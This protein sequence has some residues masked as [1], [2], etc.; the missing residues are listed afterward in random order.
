MKDRAESMDPHGAEPVDDD[1]LPRSVEP[2]EAARTGSD[3]W[4]LTC[5]LMPCHQES[6][7]TQT[8][9]NGAQDQSEPLPGSFQDLLD[10]LPIGIVVFS[11]VGAIE[12]C[13]RAAA[14]LL[15]IQR[16]PSA[17]SCACGRFTASKGS[18]VR[19]HV[20]SILKDDA[21]GS[22]EVRMKAP[23]GSMRTILLS[24][25]PIRD[26]AGA[27]AACGSAVIDVTP[28]EL[29]RAE[30]HRKQA[31]LEQVVERQAARIRELQRR[32]E[33]LERLA[34]AGRLAAGAAHEINNPLAGIA[35]AFALV[36]R[37]VPTD[38]PHR[39]MVGLIEREL[40]RITEIVRH[41]HRAYRPKGKDLSCVNVADVF[42]EIQVLLERRIEAKALRVRQDPASSDAEV[43]VAE[44]DLRQIL[45]NLLTNAIDAS[46]R[47]GELL[48]TAVRSASALNIAVSD[49]G[50][51]IA[52]DVLPRIFEPFFTTK[53]DQDAAGMGL[54][55]A[56]SK[57]LAIAMG[58]HIRA[59]TEL[60]RGSTFTL[61]LPLRPAD[62]HG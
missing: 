24:S 41:V 14:S 56:I 8:G 29:D 59:D 51:G 36:K 4:G 10:S 49:Q 9:R 53:T 7:F 26:A 44:S 1:P 19:S 47:G 42:R 12:A 15:G 34:T 31:Y 58:G 33:E 48:M 23:D 45:Y 46:P 21:P 5:R 54:G 37:A 43:L 11:Q 52:P 20:M 30:L 3:G 61:T 62:G 25:A 55:L 18:D 50:E 57:S 39:G 35:N 28:R 17:G 40:Q 22:C 60:G 6:R 27:P 16:N 32:Q 38:H 13:N 2:C